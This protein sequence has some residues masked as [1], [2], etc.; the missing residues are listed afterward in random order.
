MAGGWKSSSAICF[1]SVFAVIGVPVLAVLRTPLG[2]VLSHA[3]FAVAVIRTCASH[4]EISQGLKRETSLTFA[5]FDTVDL[6]MLFART[7]M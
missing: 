4:R 5:M 3:N 6:L 1:G 7:V 2:E